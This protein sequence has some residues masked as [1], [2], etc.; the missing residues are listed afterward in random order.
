LKI[1]VRGERENISGWNINVWWVYDM[2][3]LDNRMKKGKP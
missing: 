2:I 1:K 3:P